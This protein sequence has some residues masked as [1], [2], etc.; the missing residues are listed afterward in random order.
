[1]YDSNTQQGSKVQPEKVLEKSKRA[2][3]LDHLEEIIG[4][5]LLNNVE[6]VRLP[7]AKK[8]VTEF[9]KCANIT[10]NSTFILPQKMPI[11]AERPQ[12]VPVYPH[13]NELIELSAVSLE[14]FKHL[15]FN[16]RVLFHYYNIDEFGTYLYQNILH[17]LN[18]KSSE[19]LEH[20]NVWQAHL[21]LLLYQTD[22]SNNVAREA[23]YN[24]TVQYQGITYDTSFVPKYDVDKLAPQH[25]M[26]KRMQQIQNDLEQIKYYQQ[27]NVAQMRRVPLSRMGIFLIFPFKNKHYVAPDG[28]V[29]YVGDYVPMRAVRKSIKL[30]IEHSVCTMSDLES[31]IESVA[32]QISVFDALYQAINANDINVLGVALL[33]LR[34][35]CG[36]TI[37]LKEL[38]VSLPSEL[39]ILSWLRL[40]CD[41]TRIIL[42][43]NNYN[44]YARDVIYVDLIRDIAQSCCSELGAC[45]MCASFVMPEILYNSVH[46]F[47]N[48]DAEL[49]VFLHANTTRI[50]ARNVSSCKKYIKRLCLWFKWHGE[51]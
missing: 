15:C 48:T 28:L 29:H 38:N 44:C 2:Q 12:P 34:R 39:N 19:Q 4:S 6:N 31:N 36:N 37:T 45:M 14:E 51:F 18:A 24:D 33:V 23:F 32:R 30:L 47:M 13:D 43:S 11:L 8:Q 1:M 40:T 17:Y 20:L 7:D 42:P 49:F 26:T 41:R 35:L 22:Y 21:G 3:V 50:S 9:V 16:N 5:I 27:F 46:T 10:E 25:R